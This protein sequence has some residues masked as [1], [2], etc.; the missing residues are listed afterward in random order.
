MHLDN[1]LKLSDPHSFNTNRRRYENTERRPIV[2][3][4]RQRQLSS[5]LYNVKSAAAAL[6]VSSILD[7]RACN[8]LA[9]HVQTLVAIQEDLEELTNGA[10]EALE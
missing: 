8:R 9:E 6:A 5:A 3:Y 10:D 2:A 4:D 7:P 1:L